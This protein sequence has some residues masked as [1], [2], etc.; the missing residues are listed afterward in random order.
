MEGNVIGLN[1]GSKDKNIMEEKINSVWVQYRDNG[2]IVLYNGEDQANKIIGEKLRSMLS[3][4]RADGILEGQLFYHPNYYLGE[5]TKLDYAI[6]K[7]L[8]HLP[9]GE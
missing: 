8:Q 4:S 3:D 5:A 9:T 2:D 6:F 1:V 7:V